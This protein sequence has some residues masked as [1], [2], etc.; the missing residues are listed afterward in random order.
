M[1]YP[2]KWVTLTR[3]CELSG[4][5][6]D[7]VRKWMKAGI[8]RKGHHWDKIRGRIKVNVVRADEWHDDS[9]NAA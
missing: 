9:S 8:W 3:Y 5:G 7:A 6:E 1:V 2:V 4:T